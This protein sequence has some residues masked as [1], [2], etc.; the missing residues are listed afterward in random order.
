MTAATAR[1]ARANFRD[2][3]MSPL[4]LAT[5]FLLLAAGLFGGGGR[6]YPLGEMVVELAAIPA[7]ILA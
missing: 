3:A 6:N 5:A 2:S 7:L 1:N 4:F